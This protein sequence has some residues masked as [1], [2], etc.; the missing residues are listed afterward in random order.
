[1]S[2]VVPVGDSTSPLGS[3]S[4]NAATSKMLQLLQ[5]EWPL[6]C[7]TVF[8]AAVGIRNYFH[9]RIPNAIILAG[10]LAALV[11][12]GFVDRPLAAAGASLASA[13]IGFAF[14][15]LLYSSGMLGA[16][17]V[18][19]QTVF[20]AWVGLGM[21]LHGGGAPALIS[22]AT[23]L[24]L[25]VTFNCARLGAERHQRRHE[26]ELQF[27]NDDGSDSPTTYLFPAQ[28]TMSLAG[29]AVVCWSISQRL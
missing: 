17:N 13:A 21:H 16:A 27:Q 15:I 14:L 1:M 2:Q 9:D 29:L 28:F 24:G 3:V 8:M 6:L 26:V 25:I 12:C 11:S 7:G 19:S 23:V 5:N 20:G 22:A 4:A 18:K 10:F